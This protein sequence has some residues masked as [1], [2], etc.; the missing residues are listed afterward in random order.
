MEF[1]K[2]AANEIDADALSGIT[3]TEDPGFDEILA[4]LTKYQ[5]TKLITYA[6]TMR[7][8]DDKTV[9]FV[10]DADEW[11]NVGETYPLLDDMKPAFDGEVCCDKET[12]R[13]QWGDFI[14][15]YAPIFDPD[16]HHVVGI[17]GCDITVESIEEVKQT[18]RNLII[19]LGCIFCLAYWLIYKS[20]SRS[21]IGRDTLTGTA[22]YDGLSATWTKL[23]KKK[24]IA[25]YT[26]VQTNIKNFKIMNQKIGAAN[27]DYVLIRYAEFIQ[28]K[29]RKH[30]IVAR[31]G[32][33]NYIILI[34]SS[35]A[36]AF[37]RIM[38]E[39]ILMEIPTEEGTEKLSVHSRCGVY[40]VAGET[41]IGSAINCASVALKEARKVDTPDIVYFEEPMLES[42]I[43]E[44]KLLTDFKQAIQNKEFLVYYQPKVDI[45]TYRICGAEALV[46][47][48]RNGTIL[49]PGAFVPL[50]ERE[51]KITELDFYV[52]E[53]VCQNLSEWKR[54]GMR[55]CRISSN[56]SKDHLSDENFADKVLAIVQR[57]GINPEYLEI[58][59]TESSG[60]SNPS[61]MKRFVQRMKR[62]SIHTSIDDFGTGYSSLSML[63]DFDVNTVKIDKSFIP[64][65]NGTEPQREK[66]LFNIIHMIRDLN[67][68]VICEGVESEN[69]LHF[70]KNTDCSTVQGYIFDKPL[71]HK[72]FER[73][74]RE[75]CYPP[76]SKSDSI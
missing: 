58:E 41:T 62:A 61:A 28:S 59:L 54:Q 27:G 37:L 16:D 60:F 72:E 42:M 6:Y 53:T 31:T 75:P 30:D 4:T 51:R 13:D 49:S 39:E 76:R 43:L 65:F 35:R 34:E 7:K 38:Q 33:D 50:L 52:F 15:A 2:F 48:M 57:Y 22:N 8:L 55:L 17:V 66:I 19:F 10:V 47:W 74:L 45:H 24:K 40:A 70:L 29:L 64:H 21:L 20:F 67:K 5:N 11:E 71:T 18:L 44:S 68:T 56:F 32:G 12:T 3:S 9:E 63:K 14:S 26:V 23:A 73:R 1:A 25:N 69:Q 36:K 46:R